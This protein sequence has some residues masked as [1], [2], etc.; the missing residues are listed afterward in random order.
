MQCTKIHSRCKPLPTE[1]T[2]VWWLWWIHCLTNDLQISYCIN[3]ISQNI[4]CNII[5]LWPGIHKNTHGE[6]H[7]TAQQQWQGY[8][9]CLQ[10][11][12]LL[13]SNKYKTYTSVIFT[14]QSYNNHALHQYLETT[15][16]HAEVLTKLQQWIIW[17]SFVQKVLNTRLRRCSIFIV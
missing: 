15:T 17:H 7:Q 11:M 4:T 5:D 8:P 9:T 6:R 1:V 12:L 3:D 14:M 13:W 16:A 2:A 10:L